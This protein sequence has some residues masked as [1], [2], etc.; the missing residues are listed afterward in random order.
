MVYKEMVVDARSLSHLRE[1]MTESTIVENAKETVEYV[2]LQQMYK[3]A[4]PGE[5][6]V[7]GTTEETTLEKVE[8]LQARRAKASKRKSV[9]KALAGEGE[10]GKA[11]A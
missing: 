1:R 2:V 8:A 11:V 4:E 7:W 9:E 5:W 6:K 3:M 10:K